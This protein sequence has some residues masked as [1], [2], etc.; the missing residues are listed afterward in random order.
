MASPF[1]EPKRAAIATCAGRA[2]QPD[3]F[4][5]EFGGFGEH[6][7]A[8]GDE[9][10]AE[11]DTLDAGDEL[12]EPFR[13]CSMRSSARERWRRRADRGGAGGGA[14]RLKVVVAEVRASERWWRPGWPS[15]G[16][17]RPLAYRMGDAPS[18]T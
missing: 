11:Q 4:E 1:C 10:F 9:R 14:F 3:A 7:R 15:G 16:C 2:M 8:L 17:W 5:A 6:D 12:L 13:C 18:R